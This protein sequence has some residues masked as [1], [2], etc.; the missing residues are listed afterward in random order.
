M[1]ELTKLLKQKN[2]KKM[3][4]T[5]ERKQM[6]AK[7]VYKYL[8]KF[9]II[10]VMAIKTSINEFYNISESTLECLANPSKNNYMAGFGIKYKSINNII[11]KIIK[12][13]EN[14]EIR[15]KREY[16]GNRKPYYVLYLDEKKCCKIIGQYLSKPKKIL[17]YTLAEPDE[18]KDNAVAGKN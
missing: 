9:H 3:Q 16:F 12:T 15:I 13:E 17:E 6:I 18:L 10:N 1:K 4:N 14:F 2:I 8:Q 5:G 7:S 11:K